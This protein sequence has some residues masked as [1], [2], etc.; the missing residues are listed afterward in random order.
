MSYLIKKVIIVFN[1]TSLD[2]SY[3]N[4]ANCN[5]VLYIL[6]ELGMSQWQYC[7]FFYEN[8]AWWIWLARNM[9]MCEIY[10]PRLTNLTMEKKWRSTFL[11]TSS[12]Q[13]VRNKYTKDSLTKFLILNLMNASLN[14]FPNVGIH[15]VQNRWQWMDELGSSSTRVHTSKCIQIWTFHGKLGMTL[16]ATKWQILWIKAMRW[17][18]CNENISWIP[19]LPF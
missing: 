9:H 14:L 19:S 8:W 4:I 6:P 1:Q 7:L 5:T 18:Y 12:Q 13:L 3:D 2:D 17:N 16:W 10:L 15:R 11:S